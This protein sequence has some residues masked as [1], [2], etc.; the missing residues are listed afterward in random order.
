MTVEELRIGNIVLARGAQSVVKSID[1]NHVGYSKSKKGKWI[2]RETLTEE[3]VPI[4]LIQP[5]PLTEEWLL[6]LGFEKIGSNFE[7]RNFSIWYS[8][9]S[10]LY[11]LRFF[12]RGNDIELFV[13]LQHIH[14]LQNLYFAITGEELT[15]KK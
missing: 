5:I 12:L 2:K 9:Y 1:E 14:Q 4:T 8:Y 15:I 7:I 6:K 10:K 11:R 3:R 13:N